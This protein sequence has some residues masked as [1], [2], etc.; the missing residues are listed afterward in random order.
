MARRKPTNTEVLINILFWIGMTVSVFGLFIYA[1]YQIYRKTQNK[2]F[3][4]FK[5]DTK[6]SKAVEEESEE[7]SAEKSNENSNVGVQPTINDFLDMDI[8]PDVEAYLQELK[9][10]NASPEE[11]G[12]APVLKI[13]YTPSQS[14]LMMKTDQKAYESVLLKQRNDILYHLQNLT[15]GD[16]HIVMSPDVTSSLLIKNP[17]QILLDYYNKSPKHDLDARTS[18]EF[19]ELLI[20][21]AYKKHKDGN[22][23]FMIDLQPKELANHPLYQSLNTFIKS[24]DKPEKFKDNAI[25]ELFLTLQQYIDKNYNNA[26]LMCLIDKKGNVVGHCIPAGKVRIYDEDEMEVFLEAYRKKYPQNVNAEK[27]ENSAISHSADPTFTAKGAKKLSKALS[28][29]EKKA[30]ESVESENDSIAHSAP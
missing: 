30:V 3:H 21:L 5:W 4:Y 23:C 10:Y 25:N 8:K 11:Y 24:I 12:E 29:S 27:D 18:D 7:A 28:A 26:G 9:K 14:A 6:K 16:L 22:Q 1:A 13:D 20:K 2:S 19:C 17:S 15:S